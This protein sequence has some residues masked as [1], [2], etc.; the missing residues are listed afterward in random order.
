MT[1][2]EFDK[3]FDHRLHATVEAFGV[4]L[5]AGS[6]VLGVVCAILIGVIQLLPAEEKP[7]MTY[8]IA[9][10]ETCNGEL[11]FFVV[12]REDDLEVARGRAET[13]SA[14][15]LLDSAYTVLRIYGSPGEVSDLDREQTERE[16][17]EGYEQQVEDENRAH[18]KQR[19]DLNNQDPRLN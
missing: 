2:K 16:Q 13:M 8:L 10:V 3:K 4:V 19:Q 12:G 7:T 17:E 11:R 1:D 9:R 6:V 5:V 14:K 18:E 15:S